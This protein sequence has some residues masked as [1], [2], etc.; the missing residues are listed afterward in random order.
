MMLNGSTLH[1]CTLN[2]AASSA[3]S[4]S[5][6]YLFAG[7]AVAK[8]KV[9]CSSS[10]S[11]S[12]GG[13]ATATVVKTCT[14]AGSYGFS[15]EAQ[16]TRVYAVASSGSYRFYGSAYLAQYFFNWAEGRGYRVV[17]D[18]DINGLAQGGLTRDELMASLQRVGL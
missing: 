1:E 10:G 14:V 13:S 3:P 9:S 15:G 17:Q 2:G 4:V 7:S 11:Y 5:G 18:A 12:I 16:P 6:K 8:V